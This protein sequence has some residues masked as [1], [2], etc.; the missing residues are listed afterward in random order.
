LGTGAAW[1]DL[2]FDLKHARDAGRI[3]MVGEKKWQEWLTKL[4]A[5]F[6]KADVKY[7]NLASLPEAER[8]I[9]GG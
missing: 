7:F 5:L 9:R 2:E 3:A 6:V 8:W 1:E 4:G